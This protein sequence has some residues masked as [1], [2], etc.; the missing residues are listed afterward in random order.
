M[1]EV[2]PAD[3]LQAARA[4]GPVEVVTG[5]G[6]HVHVRADGS[7]RI[8]LPAD[9]NTEIAPAIREGQPGRVPVPSAQPG[10]VAKATQPGGVAKATVAA[11]E[12]G[13]HLEAT[14]SGLRAAGEAMLWDRT[15]HGPIGDRVRPEP[16]F[17]EDRGRPFEIYPGDFPDARTGRVNGDGT[18]EV[19]ANVLESL[20]GGGDYADADLRH[21]G[22]GA[23]ALLATDATG[24]Q[25]GTRR[26]VGAEWRDPLDGINLL[27]LP[28]EQLR[29]L[30]PR[31]TTR[32]RSP[33]CSRCS[34]SASSGGPAATRSTWPTCRTPS[35][36]ACCWPAGTA[37]ATTRSGRRRRTG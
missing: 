12:L 31:S 24:P 28:D 20:A 4:S 14:V 3:W 36:K 2:L 33:G 1:E 21:W 32:R 26:D 25:G 35:S 22:L 17:G 19:F 27:A 18:Q 9:D 10:G 8:S 37:T 30:L 5:P 13:H 29:A 34:T 7:T 16:M 15:S 11:H 23:L 6:Q